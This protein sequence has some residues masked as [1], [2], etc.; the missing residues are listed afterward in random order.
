MLDV[1]VEP[2]EGSYRIR[3]KI[4]YETLIFIRK[5]EMIFAQSRGELEKYENMLNSTVNDFHPLW[6]DDF[7][8]KWKK[9]REMRH[10]DPG[11]ALNKQRIEEKETL[12]ADLI[13]GLGLGFTKKKKM[14]I[15]QGVYK[16]WEM[17]PPYPR[18]KQPLS[19]S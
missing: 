9:L 7:E 15:T 5:E 10:P 3:E 19:K 13:D 14:K 12:L 11:N 17:F 1:P 8:A 6:P 18:E 16:L 2:T 4:D